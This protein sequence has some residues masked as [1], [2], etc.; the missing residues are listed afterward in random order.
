[1]FLGLYSL[2]EAKSSHKGKY[3]GIAFIKCDAWETEW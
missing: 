1:M 2:Q 3:Y